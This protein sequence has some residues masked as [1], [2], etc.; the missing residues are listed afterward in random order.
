MIDIGTG[1]DVHGDGWVVAP[2]SSII[3]NFDC[4]DLT[5]TLDGSKSAEGINPAT[6][7]YR[8]GDLNERLMVANQGFRTPI[9]STKSPN[10]QRR[11]S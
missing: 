8:D 3:A 4:L 7:G 10:S 11:G 9:L 6:D 2:G 1:L 5:L